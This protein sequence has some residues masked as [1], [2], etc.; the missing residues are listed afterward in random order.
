[1][2]ANASK[3]AQQGPLIAASHNALGLAYEAHGQAQQAVLCFRLALAL[4]QPGKGSGSSPDDDAALAGLLA[5]QQAAGGEGDSKQL[6]PC[7]LSLDDPAVQDLA[8]A[9]QLNLARAL[10]RAGQHEAAVQLYKQLASS[11]AMKGDKS[12]QLAYA[13][14]LQASGDQPGCEEA[15]R[16]ALAGTEDPSQ[17]VRRG[18]CKEGSC[19]SGV[20]G[21][22]DSSQC[23]LLLCCMSPSNTASNAADCSQPN[24]M[25]VCTC[26]PQYVCSSMCAPVRVLQYV[27]SS[28]CRSRL[29]DHAAVVLWVQV[30]VADALQ[31]VLLAAGRLDD[32][33]ALVLQTCTEQPPL[34]VVDQRVAG[35]W[36][37]LAA[38]SV[39]GGD[40]GM[41]A[42][43]GAHG[44][45]GCLRAAAAVH[46]KCCPSLCTRHV[47]HDTQAVREVAGVARLRHV[48]AALPQACH[49]GLAPLQCSWCRC[50]GQARDAHASSCFTPAPAGT[51]SVACTVSIVSLRPGKQSGSIV[52][53]DSVSHP[54]P[55]S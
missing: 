40:D 34:P 35:L 15:L 20:M 51:G 2:L 6:P 38:A 53:V 21:Q 5:Q 47:S 41:M 33:F 16:A 44:A 11:A 29:A 26:V 36:L 39:A 54:L 9:V 13:H 8:T 46:V 27:C 42:Q 17:Q 25:S 30:L 24:P 55:F 4:L 48:M 1:M 31:R 12:A 7:S 28:P 45:H 10:A 37:P 19:G 50:E 49:V 23:C 18:W 32:C 22:H 3:A 52:T 14:A 43:V